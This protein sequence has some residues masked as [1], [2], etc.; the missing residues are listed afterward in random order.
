VPAGHD[1]QRFEAYDSPLDMR[2][3]AA[4]FGVTPTPLADHVRSFVHAA[5]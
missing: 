2:E 1:S 5:G 3:L 4:T